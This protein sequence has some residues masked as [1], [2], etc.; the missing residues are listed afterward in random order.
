M[1]EVGVEEM[2]KPA[3][4]LQRRVWTAKCSQ[5]NIWHPQVLPLVLY[6]Y[7]TISDVTS[8]K[9]FSPILFGSGAPKVPARPFI[10]SDSGCP[11]RE[12]FRGGNGA[13]VFLLTQGAQALPRSCYC[14]REPLC[15][16]F[17]LSH[18]DGDHAAV[19]KKPLV[20]KSMKLL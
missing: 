15:G 19:R 17:S 12:H 14:R 11:S 3:N 8:S 18:F 4:S 7:D 2:E 6:F 5:L 10:T 9:K 16:S 20:I 1:G 13:C